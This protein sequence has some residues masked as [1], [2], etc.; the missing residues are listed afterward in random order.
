MTNTR[1]TSFV[2]YE[3]FYT[4]IQSLSEQ[5]R[6][7]IYE[8]VISYSLYGEYDSTKMSVVAYALFRAFKPQIDKNTIRFLNGQ[9][10]ASYGKKGASYGK[11]GGRPKKDQDK[12]H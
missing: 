9:K 12:Q 1:R 2:F 11:K 4:S 7:A 10:G 5:D 3:S 8:T 6:L